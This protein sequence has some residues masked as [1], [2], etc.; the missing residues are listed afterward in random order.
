MKK[1][2]AKI[3]VYLDQKTKEEIRKIGYEE[4]KSLAEVIR[5]AIFGF[6]E[7]RRYDIYNKV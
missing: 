6:L 3:M 1:T 2:E 4:R 5:Q 7:R